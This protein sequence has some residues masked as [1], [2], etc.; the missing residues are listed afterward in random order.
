MVTLA[1]MDTASSPEFISKIVQGDHLFVVADEVHRMG[2]PVR[3]Q[4]FAVEAGYRLGLSATP[5]RYGD[6][7]GT[8]AIIDYFGPIVQPPF[9]LK[10]AIDAEVL[11]PYFYKPCPV[12]LNEDEQKEWDDLTKEIKKRYAIISQVKDSNTMDD[13]RIQSL[14]IA[15]SR[16]LKKAE[17]KITLA[18]ELIRDY[19]QKGQKW[20]VYCEDTNQLKEVLAAINSLPGIHAFE[21]HSAMEGDRVETLKFFN[22]VVF[23]LPDFPRI[24]TKSPSSIVI[25]IEAS[26]N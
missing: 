2:S 12:A 25:I 3:R 14:M 21:Y 1:V 22:R 26:G 16:I 24:N 7:E 20:I 17:S 19:Y 13:H 8:K 15:R 9:T 18:K 23:P 6:P 10:D 11:T 5:R 4:F